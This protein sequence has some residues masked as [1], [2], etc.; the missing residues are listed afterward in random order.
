MSCRTPPLPCPTLQYADDTLIILKGQPSPFV[1]LKKIL[2]SFSQFTGLHIN[3]DKSTF[4]PMNVSSEVAASMVTILGCIV[5]S[6]SQPYLG[7]PLT[8]SKIRLSDLQPLLDWFHKYFA[9]WRGSLLNQVGHEVLVRSVL[10]SFSIY[11]MCS[12]L[13]PKGVIELLDAKRRAFLWT[14]ST[15]CSGANCKAPWDHVCLPKHKGGL[16]ISD[17]HTQNKC[18]LQ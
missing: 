5:S 9:G 6:F 8:T 7:L 18:L 14:G 4:T 1:R 12:I 13:L 17:L 11:D 10:S 15:N 2:H 16:R 3:C